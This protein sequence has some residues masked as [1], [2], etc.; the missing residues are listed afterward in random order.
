MPLI[1][2]CIITIHCTLKS[3][4]LTCTSKCRADKVHQT[5]LSIHQHD[6]CKFCQAVPH[7]SGGQGGGQIS[8]FH[9]KP[10]I[11]SQNSIELS[12][13]KITHVQKHTAYAESKGD[14]HLDN[15]EPSRKKITRFFKT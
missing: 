3:N 8:V 4:S 1:Q 15:Q 14:S 2:Y 11:H 10:F 12:N 5:K 6:P 7:T 13:L 9:I